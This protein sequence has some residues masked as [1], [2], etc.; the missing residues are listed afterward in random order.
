VAQRPGFTLIEMMV[1]LAFMAIFV[2]LIMPS[3]SR[4]SRGV[5][6]KNTC[7][8]FCELLDFAY[9]CA[10]SRRCRVVVHSAPGRCWVSTINSSLPW[11]ERG[12]LP[13]TSVLATLKIPENIRLMITQ[14]GDS[15]LIPIASSAQNSVAF[16]SNGRSDDALVALTDED[17]NR[18]DIAINGATGHARIMEAL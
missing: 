6:L 16:L 4:K 15:R 5:D 2:S 3:V 8:Q 17:G 18:V 13:E 7:S 11:M 14:T 12:E 1:V 10:V 9:V